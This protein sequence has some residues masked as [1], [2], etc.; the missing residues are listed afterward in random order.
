M[1]FSV[2]LDLYS[3]PLELLLYL[4]RRDELPIDQLS[5]ADITEQYLGYLEILSELN[6]DDV[7]EFLEIASL[8]IEM[9]SKQVLPT[10]GDDPLDE[11]SPIEDP[12]DQLVARLLEYKR[13]RDAASILEEQGRKWQL[14]YSR[15]ADDLPTRRTGLSDQPIQD[16]EVWDLVSAFGRILREQA[17]P[18]PANVIYDDTPIHVYME[19]IHKIVR[20]QKRVDLTSLFEPRMHKSTLVGMFLATLELARHYGLSTEQ[21]EPGLPLYLVA[22][23]SFVPT[24]DVQKVDNV[25]SDR[26]ARSNLPVMP[27]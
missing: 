8:L 14:R 25:S 19:R 26:V 11:S 27:R 9:K 6:L 7:A 16:L 13:I 4:V 3:G 23:E 2:D 15:L 12:S 24:L 1:E 20:T 22:G 10:Q 5:L 21:R 18:A 17:P